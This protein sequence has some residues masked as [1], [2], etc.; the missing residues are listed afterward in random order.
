MSADQLTSDITVTTAG[1]GHGPHVNSQVTEDNLRQLF[2][3]DGEIFLVTDDEWL[4]LAASHYG[5][6]TVML[7]GCDRLP[8]GAN[9]ALLL[10]H[11]LVTVDIRKAFGDAAVL[12][13]PIASFDPSLESALYTQKLMLLSDYAQTYRWTRY[14][15][16]SIASQPGPLV[17]SGPAANHAEADRTHLVCTL[18]DNITADAWLHPT[19][20]PGQW[21]SVGTLCE[22]SMTAP[23]SSDWSSAFVIDGT[24]VASGVLVARDARYDEAGDARIR[25]AE[26]LRAELTEHAPVTLRLEDGILTSV[27]AGGQDFTGA[28]RD[29]TNP[30][31]GM[32]TLELGIGTNLS[33]LPHVDW[34]FNSQLNEGAGAVHLGFGEGITGAHMDFVIAESEHEF[35]SAG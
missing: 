32:H 9:V 7:P 21:I 17:F 19:I 20:D 28:V 27:R 22:L 29:V 26:R 5:M 25:A 6:T 35:R 10:R 4:G 31:H 13:V 8:P 30:E 11:N 2:S 3:G 15:A 16:D 14:W 12:L 23:S 33:V 34:S 24:A 18:G 1:N